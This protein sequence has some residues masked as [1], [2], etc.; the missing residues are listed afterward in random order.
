MVFRKQLFEQLCTIASDLGD[1]TDPV[2]LRKCADFFLEHGQFK[3]VVRLLVSGKVNESK[4][5]ET[6]ATCVERKQ[7][8]W[9]ESNKCGMKATSLD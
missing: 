4:T 1:D 6:K 3:E 7:Q 5:C 2:L 8:V 9:T